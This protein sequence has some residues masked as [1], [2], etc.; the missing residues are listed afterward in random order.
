[1]CFDHDRD[2]DIDIVI[3]DSSSTPK[4]YENQLGHGAGKAF[5]GIRLQG[6]APNTDALGARV[7]VVADING[8]GVIDAR[9]T[10]LRS[11]STMTT[12]SA[13]I[14]RTCMWGWVLHQSF[15][16]FV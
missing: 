10:Q 2:G 3:N 7:E 4:F 15:S 13:I 1:M 8:N 5:V 9:E 11:V 12:M 14:R 16:Q 6:L